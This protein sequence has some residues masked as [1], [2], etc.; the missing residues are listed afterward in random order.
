MKWKYKSDQLVGDK[1]SETVV[2][3]LLAVRGI[4]DVGSFLEPSVRALSDPFLLEGVREG[5]DVIL[6]AIKNNKKISIYGDFDV[7]GIAASALMLI[8]LTKLNASVDFYIPHR[9]DEGYGLNKE[10]IRELIG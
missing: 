2:K 3:K 1:N 8:V 4:S 6:S 9:L 7:D 10:G 5:C